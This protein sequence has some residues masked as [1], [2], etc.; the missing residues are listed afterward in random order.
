MIDQQFIL[1][2]LRCDSVMFRALLSPLSP[3]H[4]R[5]TIRPLAP[6]LPTGPCKHCCCQV[7]SRLETNPHCQC[8]ASTTNTPELGYTFY[9]SP[10]HS[11]ALANSDYCA[12]GLGHTTGSLV[13]EMMGW[14]VEYF[15]LAFWFLFH[16]DVSLSISFPLSTVVVLY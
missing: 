16:S 15:R 7:A 12:R 14:G 4:F 3:V 10:R 8:P 13:L 1:F 2:D 11:Q 9:S 6:N 5:F